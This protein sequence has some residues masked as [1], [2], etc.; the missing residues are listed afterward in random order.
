MNIGELL[1]IKTVNENEPQTRYTTELK[2]FTCVQQGDIN[3]LIEEMGKIKATIVAGVMSND[4][5]M[6][7]KYLAV[8]TVTLATRYAIQG[9]LN[10]RVAYDF[11]D[12]FIMTVDA[13]TSSDEIINFLAS[14][15]VKLTNMVKDSKLKPKQSPHVRKCITYINENINKKISVNEL[16]NICGISS[17]HL[18]QIFKSEI[19]ETISGY[20]TKQKCEAA[21]VLINQGVDNQE[22]ASEL[23]YS[24]ASH[25]VTAFKKQTNMTPSEYYKFTK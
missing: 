6:Q 25:F 23:G 2:L 17:N 7:N 16:A 22:I 12:R 14:E 24:S 9:G 19:G 20:I 4:S 13:M 8:S 15:I 1:T 11:S 3:K 10:E 21:K 18:S 5:I